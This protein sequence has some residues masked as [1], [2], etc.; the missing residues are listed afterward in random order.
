MLTDRAWSWPPRCRSSEHRAQCCP[1]AG[2][3]GHSR[4]ILLLHGLSDTVWLRH[5]VDWLDRE[6]PDDYARYEATPVNATAETFVLTRELAQPLKRRRITVPV[7]MAQSADEAV[8]DVAVNRRYFEERF[9]HPGSRL[10]VYRRDPREGNGPR[11]ARV[12]YQNSFLPEQRIAG[13]SHQ[14]IHIAPANA[15][16]GTQGDHR[17]CGQAS[18]ES[19]EAVA[20]C[21]AAPHPWRG[22]VIGDSR[23]AISDAGPV[24]QLTYNPL[25]GELLEQVDEF[26]T[27]QSF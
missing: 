6:A 8:I 3:E 9:T 10:M 14:A 1:L 16:H 4:G 12:S 17:S 19:P 23:A 20:R 26:L 18:D 7:F 22:E 15:H 2:N 11:D 24:A 27:A 21:L 25:F 13:F 5:V